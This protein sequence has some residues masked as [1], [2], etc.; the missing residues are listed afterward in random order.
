LN[1]NG[2]Y[3]ASDNSRFTNHVAINITPVPQMPDEIGFTPTS[4]HTSEA[5]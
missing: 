4:P 1:E 2:R 5:Y 3:L